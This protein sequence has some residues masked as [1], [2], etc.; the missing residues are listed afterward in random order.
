[1]IDPSPLSRPAPLASLV[2]VQAGAVVSRI[3]LKERSGNVTLFAFGAGEGLTE[4]TT[5][6]EAL[7]VGVDGEAEITIGGEAHA[8]AAGEGL[9]LPAGVPHAVRA[10]SPFR[11]MLVMLRRLED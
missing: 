11:M 10:L 5:P 6:H 3:V 2:E 7:V 1:V 9:R 8:V 4:H